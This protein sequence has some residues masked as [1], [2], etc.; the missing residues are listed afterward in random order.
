MYFRGDEPRLQRGQLSAPLDDVFIH[1]Q[2]GSQIGEGE[3]FRYNNGDATS[4]GASSF[5]YVILLDAA[6]FVGFDGGN[7]LGFAIIS[8]VVLLAVTAVLGY[9]LGRRR[10]VHPAREGR[11]R[12][13]RRVEL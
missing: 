11:R 6:R 1:L 7:L 3:W 4:T 10:A 5:L 9:E 8:G 2:Y 12:I 13:R